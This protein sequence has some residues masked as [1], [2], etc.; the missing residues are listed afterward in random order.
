[1]SSVS[2]Q[3]LRNFAKSIYQSIYLSVCLSVYLFIYLSIYLSVCLSISLSIYLSICL[4]SYVSIHL[5]IYIYLFIYWYKKFT[6]RFLK[7]FYILANDLIF[8]VPQCTLLV[9]HERRYIMYGYIL[10]VPM[11]QRVLSKSSKKHNKTD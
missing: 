2:S 5:Y 11:N 8:N 10:L 6:F 1:M 7:M 9:T 3:I 4:C